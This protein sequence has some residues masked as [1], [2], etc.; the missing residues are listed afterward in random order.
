MKHWGDLL[1]SFYNVTVTRVLYKRKS[2]SRLGKFFAFICTDSMSTKSWRMGAV[3]VIPALKH[4]RN[5]TK[6]RRRINVTFNYI[7]NQLLL[8]TVYL[9]YQIRITLSLPGIS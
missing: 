6:H 1:S 8:S 3:A 5:V 9:Y 4:K 7:M 2:F